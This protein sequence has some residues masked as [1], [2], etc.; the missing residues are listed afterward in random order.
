MRS[1]DDTRGDNVLIEMRAVSLSDQMLLE[2]FA[3]HEAVKD[4]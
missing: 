3:S 2:Y 1:K 4:L